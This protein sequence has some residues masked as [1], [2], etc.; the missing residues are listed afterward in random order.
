MNAKDYRPEDVQTL[1]RR[2]EYEDGLLNARTNIVLVFNG[3]M[4]AAANLGSQS[5]AA[6]GLAFITLVINLF[7]L[8]CAHQHL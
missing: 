6:V 8:R 5:K 3:L 2:A 4:A 1:R 7:W